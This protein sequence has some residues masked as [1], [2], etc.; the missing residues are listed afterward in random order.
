MNQLIPKYSRLFPS[1]STRQ[2]HLER[3]NNYGPDKFHTYNDWFYFIHVDPVIRWWHAAGMVIGTLFYI[4]AALD[5]WVFGFTF[6]MVFKF[7]L[8]MFFFY[9]LPLI[10]HFYYEG[11]SAKSS[12]DKFHSTLIPV[13]H[14][15]LMTLTGRYDKWLRTYIE[16]YPFTQEAWELEEKKFSLFR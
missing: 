12:P 5:A 16:K 6:F 1:Q 4:F 2:F 14:I 11:G 9:F 15:N 10:S 3:N 8:G 13:I 7:F